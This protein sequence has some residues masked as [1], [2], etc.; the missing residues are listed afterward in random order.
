MELMI[1]HRQAFPAPCEDSALVRQWTQWSI[2]NPNP[3]STP[4]VQA[5]LSHWLEYRWSI[6][7]ER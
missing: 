6:C 2:P 1:Y 3:N 4:T 7:I 5:F